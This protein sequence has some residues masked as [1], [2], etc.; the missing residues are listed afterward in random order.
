MHSLRKE[1]KTALITGA[2]RGIGAA[3]A[4]LFASKNINVILVSKTELELKKVEAKIKS[5]YP[6]IQTLIFAANL[7]E[8][9]EVLS[10]FETIQV[11]FGSLDILVNN[12]GLF[13][14]AP[15]EEMSLKLWQ[16]VFAVNVNAMFLCSR[17]GFKLMKNNQG[18]VIL[19][20]SSLAGI[21]GQIKFPGTAAYAASK[22]AVIGLTE[23]MAV[24]GKPYNVRVNCLAPGAVN[25]KMLREAAPHLSSKTNPE[26]VAKLIANLC[27]DSSAI[28][29]GSVLEVFSN[30]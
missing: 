21:R 30:E 7:A 16:E 14:A 20:I 9:N 15:I 22:N 6:N 5:L 1:N 26:D 25:T 11:K 27:E 2:G 10:L 4:E 19:N 18:G 23:V 13:R 17:E 3:T 28:L 24:E 8:E 29:N 12:A